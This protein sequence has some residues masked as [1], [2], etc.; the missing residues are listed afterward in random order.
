MWV[1]QQNMRSWAD[2]EQG[3]KQA[4][5]G[6][7]LARAGAAENGEMLAEQRIEKEM[8]GHPGGVGE[9]SDADRGGGWGA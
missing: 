7:G 6:P 4:G 5:D 3:L 1:E 9:R 2:L 8:R